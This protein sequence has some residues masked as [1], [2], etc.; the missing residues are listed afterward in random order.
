M[1]YVNLKNN[2]TLTHSMTSKVITCNLIPNAIGNAYL[3][4]DKTKCLDFVNN[5]LKKSEC[6]ELIDSQIFS[7]IFTGNKKNQC[8]LR[9][10]QSNKIVIYN[11]NGNNL[12]NLIN[13]NDTINQNSLF[14]MD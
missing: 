6:D 4:K 10:Y 11:Q 1:S 9:H 2:A 12:F 13:E 8:Y 3:V 7:I 5:Q 14:I